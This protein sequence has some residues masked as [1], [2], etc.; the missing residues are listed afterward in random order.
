MEED[1]VQLTEKKAR[2]MLYGRTTGLV[3]NII[4]NWKAEGYIKDTQTETVEE[5]YQ[6]YKEKQKQ[7][8]VEHPQYSLI[9]EIDKFPYRI[10]TNNLI[11]R[12]HELIKKLEDEINKKNKILQ[13][14]NI[15]GHRSHEETMKEYT[16]KSELFHKE[17]KELIAIEHDGH[18][19]Y[20]SQEAVDRGY[21][22][23]GFYF[24]IEGLPKR[25]PRTSGYANLI[26]S[27][28]KK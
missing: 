14:N 23:I 7:Y 17:Y 24:N 20:V 22:T 8:H 25:I 1:K 28:L 10:M 12:Q 16:E 19:L 26:R 27:K 18:I 11:E 9:N 4:K 2:E 21:D 15:I 3:E 5:L 13:K 6:E